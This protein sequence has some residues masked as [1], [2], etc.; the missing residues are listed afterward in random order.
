MRY[1]LISLC[2]ILMVSCSSNLMSKADFAAKCQHALQEKCPGVQVTIINK[3]TLFIENS[4]RRSNFGL[5]PFYKEYEANP[6][7]IELAI[8]HCVKATG[9]LAA[10]IDLAKVVPVIKSAKYLD[11]KQPFPLVNE[12]YNDQLMILYAVEGKDGFSYLPTVVLDS[13]RLSTDT[14]KEVAI[15]NFYTT[16]LPK[17]KKVN[18]PSG[19]GYLFTTES[20]YLAS[21]IL[22]PQRWMKENVDVKGDIIV[23]IPYPDLVYVTGT[24]EAEGIEW[25]KKEVKC[26]HMGGVENISTTLFRWNGEKF[27][28]YE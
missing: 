1:V 3:K 4:A 5:S 9:L 7:A 11:G 17:M 28:K 24:E 12:R 6:A 8:E 27:E 16:V 18:S 2:C 23:A 13:M 10:N 21:M 15:K 26:V 19:K 20:Q 22:M 14:L 25:V